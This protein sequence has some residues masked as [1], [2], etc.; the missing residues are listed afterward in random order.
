MSEPTTEERTDIHDLLKR[1]GITYRQL[2][3]WIGNGWIRPEREPSKKGTIGSGVPR[4]WP[5][6]EIRAAIIMGRVVKA[7]LAPAIA[8]MVARRV[9]ASRNPTVEIAPDI[10]ISVWGAL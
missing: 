1:A 9:S 10:T 3:Y 7:G 2:D 5:D 6:D 4:T 8:A